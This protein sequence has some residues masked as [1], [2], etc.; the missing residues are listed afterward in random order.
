M[1]SLGRGAHFQKMVVFIWPGPRATPGTFSFSQVQMCVV[2]ENGALGSLNVDKNDLQELFPN[3]VY[4]K[5]SHGDQ[6]EGC[7]ETH[8]NRDRS[9]KL[10]PRRA[11]D[12][13]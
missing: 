7:T 1:L 6:R 10:S 2:L 4:F 5:G 8:S 3:K 13:F 12:H 9:I 11:N